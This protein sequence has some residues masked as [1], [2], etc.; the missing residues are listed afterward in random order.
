MQPRRHDHRHNS[1]P[2][3]SPSFVGADLHNIMDDQ[4]MLHEGVSRQLSSMSHYRSAIKASFVD[5]SLKLGHTYTWQTAVLGEAGGLPKKLRGPKSVR[6]ESGNVIIEP[7]Q[8][9]APFEL[10][11]LIGRGGF[12][13]VYL[14]E[15]EG[16]KVAIKVGGMR[17]RG[18]V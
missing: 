3:R 9:K 8:P 6:S 13:N 10:L 17:P 11:G 18:R 16:K 14:G 1:G 5:L 12:G 7:E 4:G 15:W 2:K